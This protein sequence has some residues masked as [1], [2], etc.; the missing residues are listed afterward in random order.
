MTELDMEI[1]L[2]LMEEMGLDEGERRRIIDQDTGQLYQMKG[3]DLVTPGSQGGKS[4]IEF[5]PINNA[6]MMS[7]TFSK[8]LE[9]LE[10]EESIPGVRGYHIDPPDSTG[11]IRGTVTFDDSTKISSRSYRNETTCYADLVLRLNGEE[12]VNLSK[13]D[14]DRSRPKEAVEA[15]KKTTRK[16]GKKQ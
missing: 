1:N 12:N 9:K 16:R 4:A 11:H 14:I 7:Y 2:R 3:K 10:D 8:F 15:P 5:D 13:Y 6:R